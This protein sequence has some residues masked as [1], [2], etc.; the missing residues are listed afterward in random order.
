MNRKLK[1]GD[2]VTFTLA[3][4]IAKGIIIEDRGKLGAQGERIWRVRVEYLWSP[5]MDYELSENEIEA[6]GKQIAH[7]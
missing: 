7:A 2:E 6:T 1:I 4:R 3:G 5:S